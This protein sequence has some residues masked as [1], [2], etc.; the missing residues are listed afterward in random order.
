M[1]QQATTIALTLAGAIVSL[2]AASGGIPRVQERNQRSTKHQP[3][4]FALYCLLGPVVIGIRRH[5]Q[6]LSLKHYQRNQMHTARARAYRKPLE[7]LFPDEGYGS[8]AREEAEKAHTAGANVQGSWRCVAGDKAAGILD[9]RLCILWIDTFKFL[10][11]LGYFLFAV[12]L[13]LVATV[14]SQPVLAD[15]EPRLWAWA[16]I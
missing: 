14:I 13:M 3:G 10:R 9:Q 4:I 6:R 11:L 16:G 15:L 1:R 5:G 7:D 2:S 8:S 12:P